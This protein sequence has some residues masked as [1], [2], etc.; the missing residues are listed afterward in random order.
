[1]NSSKAKKD[2]HASVVAF[3]RV[4]LRLLKGNSST[5]GFKLFLDVVSF[6]F[7]N[8]FLDSRRSTVNQVLSVLQ[9]QTS[10]VLNYL[11]NLN[12]CRTGRSQF[13]S[14]AVLSS[15]VGTGSTGNSN[16]SSS[17]NVEFFFDCL[18]KVV[19]VRD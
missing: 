16:W 11:D 12:L 10:D 15:S 6:V 4:G 2:G 13:N 14:E 9:T 3:F 18:N 17:R 5:S 7:L 1:V 8:V 19:K